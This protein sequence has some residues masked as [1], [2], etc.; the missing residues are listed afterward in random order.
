[1]EESTT[2]HLL[3]RLLH[4]SA[5]NSWYDSRFWQHPA[6]LDIDHLVALKEA[7]ESGAR[8]WSAAGARRSQT[9]W[10]IRGRS[11]PSPTT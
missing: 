7:W 6:D 3:R 11:R 4:Q 9:T 2:G 8:G 10:V 5:W 1:M